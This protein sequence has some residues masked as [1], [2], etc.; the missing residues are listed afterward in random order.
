MTPAE[1]YAASRAIARRLTDDAKNLVRQAW[2]TAVMDRQRELR[3][4][5]VYLG[6]Q[7]ATKCND[8]QSFAAMLG[9]IVKASHDR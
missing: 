7:P 9:Q 6:E 1:T 2:W 5:A 4:L 8:E 3:P